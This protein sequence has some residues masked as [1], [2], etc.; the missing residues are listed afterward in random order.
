M[1]TRVTGAANF[2]HCLA[3][4]MVSHH[5]A[6]FQSNVADDCRLPSLLLPSVFGLSWAR[7]LRSVGGAGR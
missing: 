2:R 6:A 1:S 4:K 3:E 7:Q 5:Q